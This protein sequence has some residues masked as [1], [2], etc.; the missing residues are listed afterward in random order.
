LHGENTRRI[1]IFDPG[2]AICNTYSNAFLAAHDR[3][4][5]GSSSSLNQGCCW[6]T[7]EVLYAFPLEDL[8]YGIYDSHGTSSSH[9]PLD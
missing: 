9:I 5:A 7:T 6:V 4:N 2:E 1:S 8:G 3:P